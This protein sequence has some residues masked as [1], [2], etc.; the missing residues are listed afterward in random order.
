MGVEKKRFIRK[1]LY[2]N[3][4]NKYENEIICYKI[5]ND[6]KYDYDHIYSKWIKI[7]NIKIIL[8]EANFQ[9]I[10]P[11]NYI[12]RFLNWKQFKTINKK[13]LLISNNYVLINLNYNVQNSKL[14]LKLLNYIKE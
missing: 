6:N 2:T 7:N 3:I 14:T 5:I 8:F 4:F 9:I 12:E 13:Y 1:D 10:I 11:K